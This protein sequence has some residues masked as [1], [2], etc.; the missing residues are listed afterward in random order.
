MDLLENQLSIVERFVKSNTSSVYYIAAYNAL[1]SRIAELLSDFEIIDLAGNYSPYKPFLEII[2]SYKPQ[3][4]LVEKYCYSIQKES[5]ITYFK[6]GYADERYDIPLDNESLYENNRFKK[7]ICN[8]IKT[9]HKNNVLVLNAQNI[10]SD[11]GGGLEKLEKMSLKGKFVFCFNS[12][13]NDFSTPSALDFLEKSSSKMNFLHL[14]NTFISPEDLKVNHQPVV[15]NTVKNKNLFAHTFSELRNNRIFQANEQ[16]EY[17]IEEDTKLLL[18]LSFPEEQVRILQFE[19]GLSCFVLNQRDKAIIF[20]NKVLEAYQND[21]LALASLH[22]LA[23]AFFYK[24]SYELAQKYLHKFYEKVGSNTDNPYYAL[25][26]MIEF[27]FTKKDTLK[28]ITNKYINAINQLEERGYMNN[29]IANSLSVP[30]EMINHKASLD[31][32]TK[33]IDKAYKLAIK[34]DNQHLVSM[35]CHWKGIMLSHYGKDVE[36]LKWLNEC[37]KIR[38]KIGEIVPII[39]I[40]NGLAY[41]FCCHAE[42]KK[43]YDLVN[44]SIKHL[45]TIVDYSNV[46]DTL[47]NV[48]YALFFAR[49]YKLAYEIF[50]KI[51]HYLKIFNMAYQANEA[52]LPSTTDI[53]IYKTIIDLDREDYIHGH[54][55]FAQI[56]EHSKDITSED[57]P[58]VKFIQAV[59]YAEQ[60]DFENAEKTIL[61]CENQFKKIR[62]NLS[63]KIVF[64]LY[65]FALVLSKLGKEKKAQKYLE[66][67]HQ[68]AFRNK[69]DY[70]SKH[71]TRIQIKDYVSGIKTLA[72]LN[73]DLSI[74]DAKAEKEVLVSEMHK[75]LNDY[76]FMNKIRTN[77]IKT[78]SLEKYVQSVI[79]DIFEYT[80]ADAIAVCEI[81]NRKFNTVCSISRHECFEL[82]KN[83]WKDLYS[84]S[85]KD[86]ICSFTYKGPL[87]AY[88]SNMS[89]PGSKMGIMFIPNRKN[90]P[91]K[92]NVATLNIALTAIQAQITIYKQEEN[93]VFLS[94]TD[95]LSLLQNRHALQ[96][97]L[98]V[99]IERI[100]RNKQRKR[101]FLPTTIA[102]MDMD[103]FKYYNDNFGHNAG[104]E[105]IRLFAKLLK[106]TCR[107]VD[108]I[109][110]FGGDEFVVV[111]DDTTSEAAAVLYE[112]IS[113]A[114]IKKDFFIPDLKE[115]LEDNELEISESQRIGFSMGIAS[116]SDIEDH[117]DLNT[118]LMNA[119]KALYYTK[120]NNKGHFSI[121]KDVKDKITE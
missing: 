48:G 83:L 1:C 51:Q 95:Q 57:R 62:S 67:G 101:E 24:K 11:T 111:M 20:L 44:D 25:S 63:H 113:E 15:K 119:D 100:K 65:E 80:M 59:L 27:Q 85:K 49:N 96:K 114:L 103:H 86:E 33:N 9:L 56:Y 34:I 107:Q 121:W 102:F 10:F 88:Y 87:N 79:N 68:I 30:W 8:L 105:L 17:C 37:N 21:E 73:I 28:D 14:R 98:T 29:F 60:K 7:T 77:N 42:Y 92:E 45:Y 46:I 104:D 76:Q 26:I 61:E 36:S 4:K 74:L 2:S 118:V 31:L 70:Y 38:T 110:R 71:K 6:N 16:L 72:P 108:F 82:P 43:A 66:R 47:K 69:L 112:R 116:N 12:E 93:L 22:Y 54:S 32:I 120:E 23:K 13:D 81:S 53:L 18:K 19:L 35:A 41:A 109:A 3:E 89:F 115:L 117:T 39:N 94:S 97:H 55:N 90:E 40:R 52:F 106:D 58:M 5:F 84:L 78:M 99:E 91:T 75:R 50:T 64:C